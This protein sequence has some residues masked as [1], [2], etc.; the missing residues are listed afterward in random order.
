MLCFPAKDAR[1]GADDGPVEE[2]K[3]GAPAGE[4]E[5]WFRVP[6]NEEPFGIRKSACLHVLFFAYSPCPIEIVPM[7]ITRLIIALEVNIILLAILVSVCFLVRSP[8]AAA[9]PSPLERKNLFCNC[10]ATW[11]HSGHKHFGLPIIVGTHIRQ[12]FLILFFHWF[13]Q[14]GDSFLSL[15]LSLSLDNHFTMSYSLIPPTHTAH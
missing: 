6:C 12:G 9:V 13:P 10:L 1:D 3:E 2:S 4:E 5:Q 14:K 8:A 11:S 7:T 15:S